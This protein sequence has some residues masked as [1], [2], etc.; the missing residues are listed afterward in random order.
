MVFQH[1]YC[2]H[3]TVAASVLD[4]VGIATASATEHLA[5]PGDQLGDDVTSQPLPLTTVARRRRQQA[6]KSDADGRVV[7]VAA[8]STKK[9]KT[10]SQKTDKFRNS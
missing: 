5:V 2:G 4:G 3:D 8:A 7:M 10:P 6:E 9:R 1:Q